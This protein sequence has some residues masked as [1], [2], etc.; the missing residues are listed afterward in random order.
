MQ[1]KCSHQNKFHV[2]SISLGN[3][4]KRNGVIS[5]KIEK[6]PDCKLSFLNKTKG[7]YVSTREQSVSK[8]K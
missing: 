7:N 1:V 2:T 6:C 8:N 4:S 3:P 5:W